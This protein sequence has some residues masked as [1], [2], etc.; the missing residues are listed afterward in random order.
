MTEDKK[1]QDI[2]VEETIASIQ[3]AAQNDAS[4]SSDESVL[5]LTETEMVT[6]PE[7]KEEDLIDIKSF[8]ETGEIKPAEEGSELLAKAQHGDDDAIAA[9]SQSLKAEDE[10]EA[11]AAPQDFSATESQ[12]DVDALLNNIGQ[13]AQE[14]APVAEETADDLSSKAEMLEQTSKSYAGKDFSGSAEYEGEDEV[15][16]TQTEESDEK[17]TAAS[18]EDLA[19][20]MANETKANEPQETIVKQVEQKVTERVALKAVPAATGLQVGFPVEVLAE[21]LRPMIADWVEE[22]LPSIVEKLVKEEL[23]KLA[24]K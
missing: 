24:D 8:D 23:S 12:D 16:E 15:A 21:A 3:N 17:P 6:A 11:P 20:A 13:V 14:T 2:S 7:S 4:V 22:N 1:T 10:P 18:F 9:L 19:A 5:D